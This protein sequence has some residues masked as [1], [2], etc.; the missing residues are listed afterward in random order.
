M[1]SDFPNI[2]S[3]KKYS[4][5][6]KHTNTFR[7]CFRIS[8]QFTLTLLFS[9]HVTLFHFSIH[10]VIHN[11]ILSVG[12]IEML[13][14]TVCRSVRSSDVHHMTKRFLCV[15]SVLV[16]IYSNVNKE[17]INL[18]YWKMFVNVWPSKSKLDTSA[19][20]SII[21]SFII[22]KCVI[23]NESPIHPYFEITLIQT[24]LPTYWTLEWKH[25]WE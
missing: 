1:H 19:F 20:V 2:Y 7:F 6:I 3:T 9:V 12:W 11:T 10:F 15:V 8:T 13:S 5:S 17:K 16:S 22:R 18:I 14:L 4:G 25:I 23:V 21:L 24:V